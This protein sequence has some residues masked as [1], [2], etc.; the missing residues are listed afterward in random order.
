MPA[1][2]PRKVKAMRKSEQKVFMYLRVN[3]AKPAWGKTCDE[4][5]E[6]IERLWRE[7]EWPRVEEYIDE[8]VP[9]AE[10]QLVDKAA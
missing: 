9:P 8:G 7:R 1:Y 4:Q 6:R 10:F 3:G 5:R 2:R